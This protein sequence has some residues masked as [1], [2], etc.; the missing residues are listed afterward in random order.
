[1]LQVPRVLDRPLKS[2]DWQRSGLILSNPFLASNNAVQA[3]M[4]D[5]LTWVRA[6]KMPVSLTSHLMVGDMIY[7][8]AKLLLSLA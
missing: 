1:M 8:G 3:K 2:S 7:C 4:A 6:S 5:V